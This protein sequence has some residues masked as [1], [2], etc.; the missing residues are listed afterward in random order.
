MKTKVITLIVSIFFTHHL[1]WGASKIAVPDFELLNLTI[2]L[3]D[4]QKIAAINAKDQ[5]KLRDIEHFLRKAL[6]DKAEFSVITISA[7]DKDAAD[8]GIGYLFDCAQCAAELGKSHNADYIVIGRLHKPTYLFSYIIV[9]IFDTRTNKLVKEFRSEIKGDSSKNIP[10][11][12][13]NIIA[14]IDKLSLN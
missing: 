1:A 14:K 13:D 2:Q 6:D 10:S 5:Q 7:A 12:I 3:S 8:K 11:A 9:R 4:Q